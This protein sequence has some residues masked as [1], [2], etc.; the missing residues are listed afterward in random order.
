VGELERSLT[1]REFLEWMSFAKIYPFGPRH[2]DHRIAVL[3]TLVANMFRDGGSEPVKPG[4]LMPWLKTDQREVVPA[5][6]AA[7]VS[8]NVLKHFFPP[9][10]AAN[11]AS[12]NPLKAK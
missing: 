2:D 8:S 5:A 6:S 11:A 3:A 9:H 10:R 12:I 4:D 1:Q 7:E